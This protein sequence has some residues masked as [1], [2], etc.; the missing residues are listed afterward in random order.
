MPSVVHS[1]HALAPALH[2]VEI[3]GYKR[4]NRQRL[5][6]SVG[7]LRSSAS[8][9]ITDELQVSVRCSSFSLATQPIAVVPVCS[10]FEPSSC[11]PIYFLE[12]LQAN[13]YVMA[14]TVSA[15]PILQF[16]SATIGTRLLCFSHRI[17]EG[18]KLSS[19]FTESN[20][21]VCIHVDL[22]WANWTHTPTEFEWILGRESMPGAFVIQFSIPQ[23]TNQMPSS[24]KKMLRYAANETKMETFVQSLHLRRWKWFLFDSSWPQ[25]F[26]VYQGHDINKII[27]K[28]RWRNYTHLPN[29]FLVL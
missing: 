10:P 5:T 16:R 2:K 18:P 12:F 8:L 27:N 7:H 17:A 26:A 20:T 19:I 14:V 23:S 21:H 6:N 4:T 9:T 22:V 11:I 3:N 15:A 24:K 28:H 1:C 29:G 25:T 13:M